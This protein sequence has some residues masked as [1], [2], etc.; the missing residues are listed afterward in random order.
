MQPLGLSQ[1]LIF[2]E[3]ISKNLLT[4]HAMKGKGIKKRKPHHPATYERSAYH[5]MFR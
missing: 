1:G 2:L 3:K 5:E 4:F